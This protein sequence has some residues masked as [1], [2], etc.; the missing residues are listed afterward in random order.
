[1]LLYMGI[2]D[3]YKK[4]KLKNK[5]EYILIPNDYLESFSFYVFVR[6]GSRDE[7]EKN[8]GSSHLL[9]HMLFKGT[10]KRSSYK[11]INKEFDRLGGGFNAFT[12]KNITGYYIKAPS[13]FLE[14]SIE[15]LS[16]L[17]FNSLIREEDIEKEKQVVI[18]E[19]SRMLDDDERYSLEI[20][21]K[22]AL[23]KHPLEHL[24]IGTEKHIA[25][26]S[27]KDILEYYKKYYN[28]A[29]MFIAVCGN[30][31]NIH[32]LIKKYFTVRTK[33]K[34]VNPIP[35]VPLLEQKMPKINVIKKDKEQTSISISFPTYDM[36][37]IKKTSIIQIIAMVVGGGVSSRLY[38]EIREKEALAYTVSAD[39]DFFQDAGIF[40]IVT[41]VDKESLF[42]NNNLGNKN[43]ALF[44]LFRELDRLSKEGITKDELNR[45]KETITGR[46][47]I[48]Q[49]ETSSIAEF[50]GYQLAYKKPQILSLKDVL[51][52]FNKI[53]LD[54]VKQEC[55]KLFDFAKMNISIIGG[56]FKNKKNIVDYLYSR[57]ISI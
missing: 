41:G 49:E 31:R 23:E 51:N 20:A 57:F 12:T 36:Y 26:F 52:I 27:R 53:S 39:C 54:E 24:V 7:I 40:Y 22:M 5:L 48:Q 17:L 47:I 21:F 56:G 13:K 18:E 19:L 35:T 8:R 16:D 3:N 44:I 50:Y 30:Y 45:V 33:S 42:K 43:G 28:P 46:L 1:M 25:N 29:N 10:K 4:Y 11:I 15:L 14:K 55:T 2:Y 37:D 9:E 38:E 6:A 32:K 34:F